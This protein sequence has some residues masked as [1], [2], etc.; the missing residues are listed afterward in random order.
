[1]K[2]MLGLEEDMKSKRKQINKVESSPRRH[3][4]LPEIKAILFVCTLFL[5]AIAMILGV[6]DPVVW[7]FLGTALGISVG[8][9]VPS[10]NGR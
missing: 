2:R 10:N 3:L 6:K 1:M 8:Q 7:G 4:T 9:F 5:A